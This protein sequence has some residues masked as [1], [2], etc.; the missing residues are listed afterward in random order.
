MKLFLKEKQL[1]MTRRFRISK[2]KSHLK[3]LPLK[4]K[5]F[6]MSKTQRLNPRGSSILILVYLA[7]STQERPRCAEP[8]AQSPPQHLSTKVHSLR[9]EA[10]RSTLVSQPSSSPYLIGCASVSKRNLLA[11]ITSSSRWLTVR[12][13]QV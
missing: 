12:G 13:M 1:Q 10:S 6:I 7:I 4:H 9:S 11:L 8:S 2:M 5:A 3:K